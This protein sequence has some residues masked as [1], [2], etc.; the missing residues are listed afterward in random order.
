MEESIRMTEDEDKWRKYV[1]S[2]AKTQIEQI[3]GYV[4]SQPKS[5]ST[6]LRCTTVS[7]LSSLRSVAESCNRGYIWL[8]RNAP[9]GA[10]FHPSSLRGEF[11]LTM[12]ARVLIL[13]LKCA[14]RFVKSC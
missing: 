2:V 5:K 7:V 3:P 4:S 11:L 10:Y 13:C 8:W 12:C 14:S 6:I 1:H 9:G